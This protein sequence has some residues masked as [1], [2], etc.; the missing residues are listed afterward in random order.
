LEWSWSKYACRISAGGSGDHRDAT[1]DHISG[2]FR[3]PIELIVGPTIFDRDV[4]TL[5]V[6]LPRSA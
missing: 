1:F 3:K 4:T 5:D 2:Q 6:V